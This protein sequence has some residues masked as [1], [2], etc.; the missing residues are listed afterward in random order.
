MDSSKRSILA[1]FYKDKGS[2]LSKLNGKTHECM[3]NISG[4]PNNWLGV[5][6]DHERVGY[7]A[8]YDKN[9]LVYLSA[10]SPNILENIDDD[11]VYIYSKN[12]NPLPPTTCH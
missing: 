9:K 10:D 3:N 5:K 2:T 6:V 7:E 11:K 12:P 8:T 4:F 1:G